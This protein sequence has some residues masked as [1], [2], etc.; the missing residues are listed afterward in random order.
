MDI[1][2][3]S[4]ALTQAQTMSGVSIAVL[5]KSLDNME[6]GGNAMVDMM[7]SSMEL[8]VNPAIGSNIDLYL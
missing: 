1:P 2:A 3:L 5:S 8:S 4:M 7:K 6:T